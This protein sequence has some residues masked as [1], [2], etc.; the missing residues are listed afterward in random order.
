[1][2]DFFMRAV[3]VSLLWISVSILI[4]KL[5]FDVLDLSTFASSYKLFLQC[6]IRP[7]QIGNTNYTVIYKDLM[8]FLLQLSHKLMDFRTFATSRFVSRYRLCLLRNFYFTLNW[9]VHYSLTFEYLQSN[10]TFAPTVTF[11][12]VYMK[13]KQN[14]GTLVWHIPS[15]PPNLT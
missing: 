11:D 10:R 14:F 2:L 1:M 13:L 4:P 5:S 9:L 3:C 12:L 6:G 15:W 7:P 8:Q